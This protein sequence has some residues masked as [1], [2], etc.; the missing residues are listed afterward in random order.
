MIKYLAI[1]PLV[2][3]LDFIATT[4][5]IPSFYTSLRQRVTFQGTPVLFKFLIVKYQKLNILLKKS[6]FRNI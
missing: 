4:S 1:W 2:V 5:F 6:V 3:G